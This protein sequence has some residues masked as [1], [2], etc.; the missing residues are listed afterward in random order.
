MKLATEI[1]D[2]RRTRIIKQCLPGGIPTQQWT[3]DSVT[4]AEYKSQ[5][6]GPSRSREDESVVRMWQELS[7]EF[8]SVVLER[9]GVLDAVL[10]PV[11]FVVVQALW[12]FQAAMASALGA[13]LLLGVVRLVRGHSV[14]YALGGAGGVLLAI[15]LTLLFG[16]EESYFLPSL[17][18]SG[19]TGF[20][21][22]ASVVARR[23]LVAWTSFIARRWPK[24]WYW[25]PNVRPAYAEVTVLW[26][27]YFLARLAT[28]WSFYQGAEAGRLAWLN[29]ILG[30]PA[31]VLLLIVSY[32]Y[33]TW[34][35]RNLGGPS[36]EEFIAGDEPPWEGQ[37]RGF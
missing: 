1:T 23:P 28:Q 12:S 21:C 4:I 8:N 26:G 5:A 18:T 10:P 14:L 30:W 3:P 7:D 19:L 34:R 25:H 24:E 27:I 32:L 16:G 15:G 13:A 35:L 31:T 20:L 22:F 29:L 37:R 33:G 2:W 36:V 17:L 9:G 6:Y 11:L